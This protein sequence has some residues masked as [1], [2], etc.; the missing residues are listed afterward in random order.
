[1]DNLKKM[2]DMTDEMYAF[3]VQMER[4]MTLIQYSPKIAHKVRKLNRDINN[5]LLD[6]TKQ[7]YTNV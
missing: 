6:S 1:M 3:N 5:L 2:R 7:W 4:P